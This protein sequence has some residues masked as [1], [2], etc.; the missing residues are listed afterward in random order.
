MR[1]RLSYPKVQCLL[2]SKILIA[3]GYHDQNAPRH[4][5]V[6][7]DL[8]QEG[9]EVR[10]CHTTEKGLMAK[11]RDLSKKFSEQ[12][13]GASEI[14]VTFPGHYLMPLAWYLTRI[15]EPWLA[16]AGKKRMKL[17]F[18]AFISLSDSIVS[19]RHKV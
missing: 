13:S 16:D 1:T 7:R 3:F 18:D 5:N 14:L 17:I 11:Y 19:D 2:M 12:K 6:K 15:S 10:E 4:W 8:Q 9:Y